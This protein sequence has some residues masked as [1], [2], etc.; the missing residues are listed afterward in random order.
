[1]T[2]LLTCKEFLQEL[3]DY[4]DESLDHALRIELQRHVN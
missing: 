1:M 4:L 2:R 3:N